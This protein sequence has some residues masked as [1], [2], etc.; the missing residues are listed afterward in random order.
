MWQETMRLLD[1]DRLMSEPV[2]WRSSM[3]GSSYAH[4]QISRRRG[5]ASEWILVSHGDLLCAGRSGDV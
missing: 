5:F 2:W 1:D 3:D 4:V